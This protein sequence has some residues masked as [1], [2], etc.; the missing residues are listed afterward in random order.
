MGASVHTPSR[1][2]GFGQGSPIQTTL[3]ILED[4]IAT[5]SRER[6]GECVGGFVYVHVGAAGCLPER[7]KAILHRALALAGDFCWN[8]AKL[9]E[10]SAAL[11]LYE[12]FDQAPFPALLESLCVDP[13]AGTTER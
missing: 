8:V 2:C 11:L 13:A 1:C 7:Q 5:Q 4:K 12:D 6:V 10:P 9:G 3:G